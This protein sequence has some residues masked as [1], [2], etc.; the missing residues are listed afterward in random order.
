V[1]PSGTS[2]NVIVQPAT[3]VEVEAGTVEVGGTTVFVLVPAGT[4]PVGG[5]LVAVG[6]TTVDVLGMLV[7]VGVVLHSLIVKVS[8]MPCEMPPVLHSYCV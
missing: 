1:L 7:A 6:T 3:G 2:L 8:I 4:V 5:T